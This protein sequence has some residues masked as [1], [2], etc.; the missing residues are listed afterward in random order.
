LYSSGDQIKE[1]QVVEYVA[2]IGE[3]EN[4]YRI[5][6]GRRE[7]KNKLEDPSVDGC[8]ILILKVIVLSVDRFSQAQGMDKGQVPVNTLLTSLWGS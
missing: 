5:L 2:S 1:D 6:V 4:S 3:K 7:E 8:I